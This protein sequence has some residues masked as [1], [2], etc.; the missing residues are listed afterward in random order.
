M[1]TGAARV[2]GRDAAA[3]AVDHVLLAEALAGLLVIE[4]PGPVGGLVQLFCRLRVAAETGTGHLGSS[5][6]LLLEL[7][8]LAVICGGCLLLF[9]LCRDTDRQHRQAKSEQKAKFFGELKY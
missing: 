9:H 4:L 6:E 1:A 8:E 5:R 2:V 7:L 3:E